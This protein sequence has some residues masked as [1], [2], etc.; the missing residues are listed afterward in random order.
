MNTTQTTNL[1]TFKQKL[2]SLIQT[3]THQTFIQNG[4]TRSMLYINVWD[5]L[6]EEEREEDN[7]INLPDGE[8]DHQ[9]YIGDV[10]YFYD[11]TNNTFSKE[12]K[13]YNL[14]YL[15]NTIKAYYPKT[16]DKLN[17]L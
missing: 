5:D 10:Y 15:E 7:N 16:W 3:S 14:D 17:T 13:Y 1:E 8:Y 2:N 6:T 4:Q 9:L 12:I 11:N